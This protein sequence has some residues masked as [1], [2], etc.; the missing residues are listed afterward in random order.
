MKKLAVSLSVF[1]AAMFGVINSA[2]AQEAPKT[3]EVETGGAEIT[4]EK[5]T[6]SYGTIEN[7]ANGVYA[8]KF[9][10]NGNEPLII[11]RAKGSC[12]CT[13]P[14]WP[15]EPILPG[16]TGEIS[17]KYDTK[18]TGPINKSVTITSNAKTPTTVLRI[19]GTVKAP[20]VEPTA[21]VKS[22][23]DGATPVV[24]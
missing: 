15:K 2:S 21:P 23:T 19:K 5:S 16:E 12:G 14:S 3:I 4:F 7:G 24:K 11:S 10:N 9:T 8:F 6:H 20:V 1:A 17:V 22:T 18:R 13:V